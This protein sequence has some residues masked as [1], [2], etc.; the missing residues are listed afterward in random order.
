MFVRK[1]FI[2]AISK[3]GKRKII[4]DFKTYFWWVFYEYDQT[5]FDGNQIK[6]IAK[7]QIFSILYGLDQNTEKRFVA[8]ELYRDKGR[9][10]LE[11]PKFENDSGIITPSG[12]SKLIQWIFTKPNNDAIRKVTFA[13]HKKIL[14]E[15]EANTLHNTILE[16]ITKKA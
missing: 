15:L 4:V 14:N 11:Y 8:L 9:I 12:I 13:Y 1:T 7:N 16:E 2:M 3:K 10:Y 5:T 6:I